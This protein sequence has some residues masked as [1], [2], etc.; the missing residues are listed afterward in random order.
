MSPIP[1]GSDQSNPK[2]SLVVVMIACPKSDMRSRTG[3]CLGLFDPAGSTLKL[4]ALWCLL[5]KHWRVNVLSPL[6]HTAGVA[7]RAIRACGMV[8]FDIIV[9]TTCC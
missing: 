1:G 3:L 4:R 7:T 9:K 6:I 5:L 2:I 8:A